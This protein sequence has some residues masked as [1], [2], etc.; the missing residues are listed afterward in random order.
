MHLV[1]YGRLPGGV[2][3]KR[4]YGAKSVCVRLREWAPERVYTP[5]AIASAF[6]TELEG[7][8]GRPR[9]EI[10]AARSGRRPAAE[11]TR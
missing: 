6:G 11:A 9:R 1:R 7:Q 10:A 2:N 8:R 5:E 4:K 3:A